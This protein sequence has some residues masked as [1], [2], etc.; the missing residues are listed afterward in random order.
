MRGLEHELGQAP[1]KPAAP[2]GDFRMFTRL[3]SLSRNG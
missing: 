3:P 1:V 2:R